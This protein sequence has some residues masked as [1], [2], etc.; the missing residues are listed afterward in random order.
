MGWGS[1]T[2]RGGGRKLRALPRKFVFLGFRREE[3]GMSR[4]FCWDVPDPW[5]C[6]ESLCKKK[7][8]LIFRSLA[9]C[10]KSRDLTAIAIFT[11]SGSTPT[12]GLAPSETMVSIPLWAQKT[13]EIKGFLGLGCPFLDLV[14]QTPRP[15]GRGRPLF[16]E[17]CDSNRDES[18]R[19]TSREL[20]SGLVLLWSSPSC[21]LSCACSVFCLSCRLL[22]FWVRSVPGV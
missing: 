19:M 12:H 18:W 14:S 10:S 20:L 7:F 21:V 11:I 4:E 3:S 9:K 13:L 22:S 2:R 5:G 6:S 17:I 16:A 1:S 8:V 15:R